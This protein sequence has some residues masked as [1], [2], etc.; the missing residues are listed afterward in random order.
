MILDISWVTES[1]FGGGNPSSSGRAIKN[2]G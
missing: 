1:W 2:I